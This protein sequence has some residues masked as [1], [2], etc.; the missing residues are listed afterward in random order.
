MMFSELILV[1]PSVASQARAIVQFLSEH[2]PLPE[3]TYKRRQ[4]I[5]NGG[6]P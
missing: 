4:L 6:K 3:L 5:H 1:S 2:P